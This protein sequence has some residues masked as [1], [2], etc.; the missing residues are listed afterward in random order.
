MVTAPRGSPYKKSMREEPTIK[1]HKYK[2]CIP[3]YTANEMVSPVKKP[4]DTTEFCFVFYIKETERG[5]FVQTGDGSQIWLP[6]SQLKNFSK[7]AYS[8]GDRIVLDISHW[9]LRQDEKLESLKIPIRQDSTFIKKEEVRI[10]VE[11]KLVV[12]R[13]GAFLFYDEFSDLEHWV[14][15][16]IVQIKGKYNFRKNKKILMSLPEWFIK[17][18]KIGETEN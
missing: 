18:N 2:T 15:K 10:I 4:K 1:K 17:Q 11:G 7:N 16:S 9:L 5:L 13:S 6:I 14:P 3:E 8:T 12:D